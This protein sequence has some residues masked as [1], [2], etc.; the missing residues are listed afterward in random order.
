[1][2]L[3][4]SKITISILLV[5]LTVLIG[6]SIGSVY[7][8]FEKI[9]SIFLNHLFG[10]KLHENINLG[11]IAIILR[12]RFPRVLIGMMIGGMISISGAAIQSILNN[13]LA[14]PYTLGVSSGASLGVAMIIVLNISIPLF[15]AFLIPI[16]GFLSSLLVVIIIIFITKKIDPNF[17]NQTIILIGVVSSLFV[18]GILTLLIAVSGDDLK[19]IIFWQ[20]GSL[21]LKGYD[22][23]LIL[24]PF[25][26]IGT[27]ILILLNKELDALSFGDEKAK[28]LGVN[29]KKVR[30]MI[31][32][33]SS[34][35]SGS[36]I[37]MT[38]IIG[39]IGLVAPHVVRRIYGA[40]HQILLPMSFL[41]GGIF[42]VISDLIARTIVSPSELPVGS[43]TALIGAPFFAFV[44]FY[45]KR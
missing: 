2:T 12:I 5:F 17:N 27:L 44:F 25:C 13:P 30:I 19:S 33:V 8:S 1:M 40:K 45:K 22:T 11:E 10:V 43:V 37:A 16:T 7:I 34:L 14:S 24:L 42:L 9:I 31:I 21:S 32:I 23:F 4:K 36:A 35:L 26:I 3:T 20:M 39:F 15:G 6:T 38:G 28:S 29:S 41:F 18:N